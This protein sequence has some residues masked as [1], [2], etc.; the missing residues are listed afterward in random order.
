[1]LI[2]A[3]EINNLLIFTTMSKKFCAV[4]SPFKKIVPEHYSFIALEMLEIDYKCRALLTAN[5][6]YA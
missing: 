2:G 1:M 4:D 5:S 6:E 3:D